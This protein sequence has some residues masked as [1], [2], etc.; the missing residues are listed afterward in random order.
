MKKENAFSIVSLIF[1]ILIV[2]FVINSII[3]MFVGSDGELTASGFNAFKFFTV[4]SNVL[5]GVASLIF[6]PFLILKML[7]KEIK[8]TL[9]LS[10]A[11][12]VATIGVVLTFLTV[13]LFLGFIFG[14]V[15]MFK[16]PNLYMHLITPLLAMIDFMFFDPISEIPFRFTFFGV[17]PMTIYGIC[18][19]TNIAVHNGYGDTNYDWYMF[20][21]NGMGIGILIFLLMI[22][23]TY[24]I[25]LLLRLIRKV[26]VK[27]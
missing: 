3:M 6:L 13:I 17:V 25:G 24:G 19:I 12:F 8:K 23:I 18:Y 5:M 1:N 21:A 26:V 4:D 7:G 22:S 15:S 10:V 27:K 14:Y 16:G 11:K 20:G 9:L 2:L